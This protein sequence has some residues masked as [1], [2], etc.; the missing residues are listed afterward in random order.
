MIYKELHC[1]F[2]EEDRYRETEKTTIDGDCDYEKYKA[3]LFAIEKIKIN[4]VFE[5]LAD[6]IKAARKWIDNLEND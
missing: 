3:Y 4:L 1:E 5:S 6:A 2:F